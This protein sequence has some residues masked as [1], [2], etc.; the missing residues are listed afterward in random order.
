M[1]L[2]PG[3]DPV[4]IY[5]A[6]EVV[7]VLG[8]AGPAT[9]ARGLTGLAA[10]G[11]GAVF[12]MPEIAI[13]GKKKLPTMLAFSLSDATNHDPTLLGSMIRNFEASQGRK[14]EGKEAGRR[15]K[16]RLKWTSWEEDAAEENYTFKRPIL[17]QFQIVADTTAAIV[18]MR[19]RIAGVKSGLRTNLLRTR[20]GW[21][22]DRQPSGPS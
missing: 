8:L 13:V 4:D 20:K 1:G 7:A 19:N 18:A 12:L 9:L 16:N 15:G 3:A 14:R 2:A 5:G 22:R 11:F 6:A 17:W 10:S 21:T